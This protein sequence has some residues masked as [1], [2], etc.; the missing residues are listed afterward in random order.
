[1]YPED[2]GRWVRDKWL[3][4]KGLVAHLCSKWNQVLSGLNQWGLV[5]HAAQFGKESCDGRETVTL[6]CH[7]DKIAS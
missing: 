5:D 2:L 1:M 4:R 6:T 7:D 3:M